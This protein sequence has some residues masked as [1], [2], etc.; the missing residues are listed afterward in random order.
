[1]LISVHPRPGR[2]RF[3]LILGDG[4]NEN[5]EDCNQIGCFWHVTRNGT[6]PF[7]D[8]SVPGGKLI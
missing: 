6:V 3:P 1:M 4:D 7:K 8:L 5:S 2:L